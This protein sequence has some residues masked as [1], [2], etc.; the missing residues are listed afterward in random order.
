[1]RHGGTK[2]GWFLLSRIAMAGAIAVT[3]GQAVHHLTVEPDLT[4]AQLL[5]AH[6]PIYVG[7]VVMLIC[8]AIADKEYR[9]FS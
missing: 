9:S 7:V 6:W 1:M 2:T 4:N 8:G 5:I 3:L